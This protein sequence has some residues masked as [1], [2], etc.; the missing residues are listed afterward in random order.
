MTIFW[1]SMA[2]IFV[3]SVVSAMP[4]RFVAG[5]WEL[6]KSWLLHA[7]HRRLT[8]TLTSLPGAASFHQ[9]VT[10]LPS[11]VGFAADR[12]NRQVFVAAENRHGFDGAIIPVSALRAYHRG[13]CR[14][15]GFYDFFVDVD[16]ANASYPRW[17][18]ICGEDMELRGKV[19]Q[20]LEKLLAA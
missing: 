12:N 16:V 18:I 17:R 9:E 13:E 10:F 8:K 2:L 4:T 5:S 15:N 1:T 11:G 7:R 20:V 6:A 19:E 14:D 3:L